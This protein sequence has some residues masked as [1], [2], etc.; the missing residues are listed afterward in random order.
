MTTYDD[1]DEGVVSNGVPCKD[2]DSGRA[3][4]PAIAP[5]GVEV[6][7]PTD[8]VTEVEV[9]NPIGV[10]C[11]RFSLTD[12]YLRKIRRIELHGRNL[13]EFQEPRQRRGKLRS[14]VK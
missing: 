1:V 14:V 9:M 13:S 6:E 8:C 10:A 2:R 5:A 11:A 3:A 12:R 4:A 7:L